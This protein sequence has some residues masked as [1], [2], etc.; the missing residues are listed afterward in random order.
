[1]S[2]SHV[3]GPDGAGS[4]SAA[5]AAT[6]AAAAGGTQS[7]DSDGRRSGGLS[8]GRGRADT[9]TESTVI[10]VNA[11]TG[12]LNDSYQLPGCRSLSRAASGCGLRRSCPGGTEGSGPW[13]GQPGPAAE[14][15]P[16]QLLPVIQRAP[17]AS[18][19]DY[20]LDWH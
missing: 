12:S 15:R 6:R 9:V 10:R 20:P 19:S 14:A 13:P 5:A 3:S 11:A 4:E 18:E 7:R 1:M 17:A 16:G 2:P 8:G